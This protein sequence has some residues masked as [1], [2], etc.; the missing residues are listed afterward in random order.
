MVI[1]IKF[2]LFEDK[3]IHSK[4]SLEEF[5]SHQLKTSD[6]DILFFSRDLDEFGVVLFSK[7]EYDIMYYI[8]CIDIYRKIDYKRIDTIIS[9]FKN[10]ILES[11]SCK[12]LSTIREYKLE[13]I[14]V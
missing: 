6:N 2:M 14:G 9:I 8:F 1:Y 12:I 11:I 10:S 7:N 3:L 4:I 13:I 5:D